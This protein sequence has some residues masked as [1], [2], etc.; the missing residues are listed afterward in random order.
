MKSFDKSTS[1]P[2]EASAKGVTIQL[3]DQ[4]KHVPAGTT[5]AE[6]VAA[7]CH[8]PQA[9]STAV[10]GAFV[11]RTARDRVLAEGDTVL[12]FQPIVGG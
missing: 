8:A 11:A 2:V 7:L 5:L 10:N 1:A 9:V 3:D 12:L 6:L 4:P